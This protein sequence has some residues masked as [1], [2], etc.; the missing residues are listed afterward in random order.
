MVAAYEMGLLT[1]SGSAPTTAFCSSCGTEGHKGAFCPETLRLP[2]GSW[3]GTKSAPQTALPAARSPGDPAGVAK[4]ATSAQGSYAGEESRGTPQ[5]ATGKGAGRGRATA[6][7]LMPTQRGAG[8]SD[9][10]TVQE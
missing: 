6:R 3:A 5:R 7:K 9:L 1:P 10:R 4:G 2:G 8:T